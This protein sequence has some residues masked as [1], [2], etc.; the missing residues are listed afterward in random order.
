MSIV[1]GPRSSLRRDVWW[2]VAVVAVAAAVRYRRLWDSL[3]YDEMTTLIQ[4]VRQPWQI[5][6]AGRAGQYLPNNHVLHTILAKLAYAVA[7]PADVP[8]ESLLRLPAWVAGSV[9]PVA[10]AWPLRRR[11]PAVALAVAVVLAV[12][13]WLVALGSEARGY[14][15]MLLLGVVATNLLPRGAADPRPPR[16]RWAAYAAALAAAIYTVPLA[17]LL[18]PAHAVAVFATRPAAAR[19]W[20]TAVIVA[21]VVTVAVYVPMARGI[22]AYYRHPYPAT[23]TYRSMLDSLP[24]HALAGERLPR[25][26]PDPR[27]LAVPPDPA[28]AA[29]Y[30]ALPVFAVVVG[31]VVGAARFPDARPLLATLATVSAVTALLPLAVPAAAEVRFD[32]WAAVWFGLSAV[33]LLAAAASGPAWARAVSVAGVVVLVVQMAVWDAV[34]LPNQ[35]IRDAMQWVDRHAPPDRAVVLATLG[36]VEAYQLYELDVPDHAVI[37][38]PTAALLHWTESAVLQNTGRLPWVVTPFEPLGK[39]ADSVAVRA[40][41]AARYVR[42]ARFE[43]RLSPVAV[44]A[45]RDDRPVRRPTGVAAID[46]TAESGPT[47]PFSGGP[48]RQAWATRSTGAA[49]PFGPP[50]NNGLE[51]AMSS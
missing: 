48:Q 30:W 28:G 47:S 29:V 13:P 34:A 21:G 14:T 46:G 6:L 25:R 49:R 27:T 3:W 35:P 51:T 16:R 11:S 39:D 10:V 42:V 8:V 18:V 37:P 33:L 9:L 19:R 1:P 7:R 41:L 15:L 5:V 20:A 17:V 12:H 2:A 40:D 24:R 50:L 26:W 22:V 4:Y 43:G 36:G 31:S 32:C 45:P 23:M 38:A 44:Y